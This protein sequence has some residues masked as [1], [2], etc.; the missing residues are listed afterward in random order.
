MVGIATW[1]WLTL[2]DCIDALD[3]VFETFCKNFTPLWFR[4][5]AWSE[6]LRKV[7]EACASPDFLKEF[8]FHAGLHGASGCVHTLDRGVCLS[9]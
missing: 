8:R 6:Q 7:T 5:T 9:P 2:G 1:R 4:N 3:P